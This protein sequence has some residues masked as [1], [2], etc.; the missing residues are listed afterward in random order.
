[1][2]ETI[3]TREEVEEFPDA[4]KAALFALTYTIF[5]WFPEYFFMRNGP[6]NTSD[7]D[8]QYEEID[9]LCSKVHVTKFK[10]IQEH[11]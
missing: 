4:D 5:S 1:V 3:F 7:R 6:G 8:R 9:Y 10:K 11:G 2:T